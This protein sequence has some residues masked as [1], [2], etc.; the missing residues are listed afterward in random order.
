MSALRLSGPELSA[1][2]KESPQ[3]KLGPGL[4][5]CLLSS[6]HFIINGF[7]AAMREEYVDPKAC[8]TYIIASWPGV[9]ALVE[10][11][12]CRCLRG[13]ESQRRG[14]GIDTG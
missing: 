6:G 2:A 3:I 10:R 4:S 14:K 11:I 5:V 1:R 7:Y 8:V 12:P 9:F 13:H